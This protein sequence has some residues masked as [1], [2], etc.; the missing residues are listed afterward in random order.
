MFKIS[1]QAQAGIKPALWGVVGGAIATIVVGF[2]WGGWTLGSTAEKMAQQ[3]AE[4]AQI[5]ILAPLCAQKFASQPDAVTK[6]AALG[7]T[8]S[9]KRGEALQ[10]D[11]VTLP[12]GTYQSSA[13]A[14]ACLKLILAPQTSAAK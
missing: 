10:K 4:V 9:W 14:D 7:K 3:R 2:Y 11:W 12:G 13:L 5:A 8:D 6:T 1:P